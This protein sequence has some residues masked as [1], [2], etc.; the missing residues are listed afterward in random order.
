MR[1]IPLLSSAVAFLV[2][3]GGV[4][5]FTTPAFATTT[6]VTVNSYSVGYP[7]TLTPGDTTWY[8][9]D[10]R[11]G[12]AI[13]FT[14]AYGAP[15]GLGAGSLQMTTDVTNAAKSQLISNQ[16]AGTPLSNVSTLSYWT[17]QATGALNPPSADAS[18][19]LQVNLAGNVS[20]AS[21]YTTLVY[22][23]YWNS[24]PTPGTWQQWDM[25]TGAFWSSRTVDGLTAGHGG[26][27]FY[28]IAQVL[29]LD[30]NAVVLGIGVNVGSYNPNYTVATDGITFG[31]SAGAT[32][33]NFEVPPPVVT[34][35]NQCKGGGWL[36]YVDSAGNAFN[37][38]GDC[39]SYV[40]TRGRN[41]AG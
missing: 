8:T 1:P 34:S 9:E 10:T 41:L 29:A 31:T 39:V 5:V 40:A 19:Q 35:I 38:Q 25:T 13:A 16:F 14:N 26:A 18:F 15:G 17:Y 27:P 20:G 30:P 11:T 23:P 36:T 28:T 4:G 32:V 21:D 33:F 22:E 7:A 2:I 24:T 6:S 3:S 37:N 12:G